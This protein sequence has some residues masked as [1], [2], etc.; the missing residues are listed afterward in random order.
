MNNPNLYHSLS[1]VNIKKEIKSQES[2]DSNKT[3]SYRKNK[4]TKQE[5]DNLK[6]KSPF[7]IV[8]S[9]SVIE[10]KDDTKMA[11]SKLPFSTQYYHSSNSGNTT[12]PL[13]RDIISDSI[14]QLQ[15]RKLHPIPGKVH[16][17]ADPSSPISSPNITPVSTPKFVE[18]NVDENSKNK[19]ESSDAQNL[20]ESSSE[21]DHKDNSE[22]ENIRKGKEEDLSSTSSPSYISNSENK[23]NKKIESDSNSSISIQKLPGRIPEKRKHDIAHYSTSPLFKN[24]SIKKKLISS[25]MNSPLYIK[26]NHLN[27]NV[28]RKASPLSFYNS[29]IIRN[30]YSQLSRIEEDGSSEQK[31]ASPTPSYLH[32]HIN[33]ENNDSNIDYSYGT[34][35]SRTSDSTN[36]TD[37]NL[38]NTTDQTASVI[39]SKSF[40][41]TTSGEYTD[42]EEIISLDINL[43]SQDDASTYNSPFLFPIIPQNYDQI[44]KDQ[45]YRL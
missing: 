43:I 7:S 1:D 9:Q 32:H 15:S 41:S 16:I 2:L 35:V 44:V 30:N 21:K 25:T 17:L 45:S 42:D 26:T 39:G 10:E 27:S 13:L 5:N 4:D 3:I 11:A 22:K 40:I 28:P 29:V 23:N 36:L 19:S 31:F 33:L 38:P 34:D 6:T 20:C 24:H 14:L 18:S 12:V 37:K 8:N